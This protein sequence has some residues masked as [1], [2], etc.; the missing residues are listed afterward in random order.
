M[1]KV[2]THVM[3]FYNGIKKQHKKQTIKKNGHTF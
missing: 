1:K 2:T 3:T